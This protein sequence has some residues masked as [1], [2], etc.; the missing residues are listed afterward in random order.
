MT[1]A[2]H[3]EHTRDV[4]IIT[5]PSY[6]F[7]DRTSGAIYAGVPTA[8]FGWECNTVDCRIHGQQQGKQIYDTWFNGRKYRTTDFTTNVPWSIQNHKSLD[9]VH[10]S[11]PVMCSPA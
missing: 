1:K 9:A 8:D 4:N 7:L 5:F 3:T 6:S 10:S 11:H 2:T